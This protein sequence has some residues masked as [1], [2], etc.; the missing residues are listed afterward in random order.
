M[1][2]LSVLVPTYNRS[3]ELNY[4]LTRLAQQTDKRFIVLVRDN[5]S[6]ECERLANRNICE[7]W[8]T[9]LNVEYHLSC[10]NEGHVCNFV[11]LVSLVKTEWCCWLADDDEVEGNFVSKFY[12][13]IESR[14]NHLIALHPWYKRVSDGKTEIIQP[15]T[16]YSALA[17]V[18]FWL[19]LVEPEKDFKHCI[20]AIYRRDILFEVTCAFSD[21]IN[22]RELLLILLSRGEYKCLT[23]TYYIKNIRAGE[24]F[25]LVGDARF[26]QRL[27]YRYSISYTSRFLKSIKTDRINFRLFV[28][29]AWCLACVIRLRQVFFRR[30]KN[31]TKA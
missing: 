25:N 9:E 20:Y 3:S 28:Y 21:W 15:K 7:A 31:G 30:G 24:G 26:L 29:I 19:G 18:K 23:G 14:G 17:L 22:E 4:C 2:Q 1:I 13:E 27:R 6:D 16:P 8:E 12:E 5:F 11:K 10:S